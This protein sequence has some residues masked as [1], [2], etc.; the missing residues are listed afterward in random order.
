[1]SPLSSFRS[2]GR[3][4]RAPWLWLTW[5]IVCA[6]AVVVAQNAPPRDKDAAATVIPVPI[7]EQ[8]LTRKD[9]IGELGLIDDQIAALNRR[10]RA[11]NEELA[12]ASRLPLIAARDPQKM[13]ERIVR[14]HVDTQQS[15]EQELLPHQRKRMRQLSLQ[16]KYPAG[17]LRMYSS[18]EFSAELEYTA[19]QEAAIRAQLEATE[20]EVQL[21]VE[22]VMAEGRARI[23]RLL[24]EEQRAKSSELIGT[25]FVFARESPEDVRAKIRR[26]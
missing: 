22:R 11:A 12:Q 16:M 6:P 5:M 19:D 8:F 3:S 21:A 25:P 20:R 18:P 9:V 1:M 26:R 15:V 10:I 24:T 2:R 13:Q 7:L 17:S 4:G 23:Q 14:I